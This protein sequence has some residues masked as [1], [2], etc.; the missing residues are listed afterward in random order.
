MKEKKFQVFLLLILT[1]FVFSCSQQQEKNLT[2]FHGG[3]IMTVDENF[4]E[5]EALVVEDQKII[6]T[7]SFEQMED[8]FGNGT[9]LID[10]NGKTMLPGFVDPHAHVVSFAPIVFLTE[11]IGLV[12]FKTTDEALEH[13]KKIAAETEAGEWIM[14]SNWD[15]AVQEGVP[16][17]T[18]KELDGVS[19]EHPIF[20]LNTSG[21][22]AYVNSK[23]YQVAGITNAVENPPGAEYSRDAAGN[24]NGVMKNNL[25]F[26]PVWLSNP[27]VKDLDLLD[28]ITS[29][30]G[31]F[32][33]YGIT[34]TSDLSLGGSTRSASE[35]DLLIEASGR[36][37][38]TAR[39][40][41]Y[42]L[43]SLNDEWT[44]AGAKM[45]DGNDMAMLTGF[46]L[47]ADGS[48][49]GF[50]GLQREDYYSPSQKGNRG[51]QY[52]TVEEMASIA[53]QRAS[54]GWQLAI[55]GN[56]DKAIDNILEVMQILKDKGYD[57]AKI[58]P[59]IEHCSILH[60]EQIEKMKELGVSA[61]FLIGH[62]HY[63]GTFMR[64]EVFGPEKVQL[65]DRCVSVEKAGISYTLQSD[66]AVVQPDM[67]K[68]VEIAVVRN[69]FKEPEY[70]LAPQERVSVESAIR[71]ITSEAAWQLMVEDKIGSLEAGKYADLVILEEDP[72]KVEPTEISEIKVL[73]TWLN[74]E[75][76]Y[77]REE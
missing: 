52:M 70:I 61:S 7:G 40:M 18:F 49:Q 35:F 38:F 13:L 37:D 33:Q 42:P 54:E 77:K 10:L 47:I 75:R 30:L 45:Y 55:H 62:V 41:A 48:N 76:V 46:K 53:E 27:K 63:W 69:T 15:P 71:A 36:E 26:L 56:G 59:R 11:D 17:L 21:H 9:R 24:L 67:L 14:A 65:L 5:V 39:V 58:R 44:E 20:V 16:A 57:L 29:L 12:N 50:T 1:V 4:S 23:A 22:L 31:D 8:Q 66:F 64:D 2:L 72:R 25:A 34:T 32:N 19:T 3:T 60:D 6:A 51:V 74:G 68:M 73:E 43:Y 28:A